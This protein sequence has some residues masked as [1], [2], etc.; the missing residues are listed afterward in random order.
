MKKM[1]WFGIGLIGV[2]IAL[3]AA[4][5]RMPEEHREPCRQ[6][7][8]EVFQSIRITD[9]SVDVYTLPDT[10][11][12]LKIEYGVTSCGCRFRISR[13]RGVLA[14]GGVSRPFCPCQD[15][16]IRLG[17]PKDFAGELTLT[18]RRELKSSVD[19]TGVLE[20]LKVSAPGGTL[21]LK[22]C[23]VRRLN[24]SMPNGTV[25]GSIG[26]MPALPLGKYV[27]GI[28]SIKYQNEGWE[29][30]VSVVPTGYLDLTFA[31]C[32]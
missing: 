10:E 18:S 11:T 26:K 12:K 24:L 14:I 19:F 13:D 23:R 1:L 16:R 28:C 32:R 3:Q 17:L 9:V 6:T 25:V 31:D 27:R 2:G 29:F 30:A 15:N 4:G 5:N 22:D 20:S 21:W 7:E 8:S